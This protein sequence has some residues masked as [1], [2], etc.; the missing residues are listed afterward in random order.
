MLSGEAVRCY[1][2]NTG[3]H[4]DGVDCES[5]TLNDDLLL[6][7]DDE[8]LRDYKNYT[9]C[10]KFIQEGKLVRFCSAVNSC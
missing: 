9:M 7:C 5:D 6:N 1:V 8:G 2:C 4:Y 3:E 10:R